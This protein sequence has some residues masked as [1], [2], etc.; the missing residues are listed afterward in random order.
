MA[1]N[2]GNHN[3]GAFHKKLQKRLTVFFERDQKPSRSLARKQTRE[4]TGLHKEHS[5]DAAVATQ[6]LI[7]VTYIIPNLTMVA[8][9]ANKILYM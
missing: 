7:S 9:M 8:E 6:L 2:F 5:G 3:K 1:A 4:L